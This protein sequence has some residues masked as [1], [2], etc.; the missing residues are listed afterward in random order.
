MI[1]VDFETRST[2]NLPETGVW[3]YAAHPDTGIWCMAFAIG[4]EEPQVWHE[5]EPF[6]ERL[7]ERIAAGETLASW[8]AQFERVIWDRVA[9]PRYGFPPVKLD[10]WECIM[11]RAAR[12]GFPLHLADAAKF[13]G[14]PEQKDLHGAA[15]MRKMCRPRVVVDGR[16]VWW[17]HEEYR[18]ALAAYCAQDV[19][20]E[21]ELAHRLPAL[22][23]EERRIFLLDARIND[24]GVGVDWELVDALLVIADLA[25]ADANDKL[26]QITEGQVTSIHQVA[27]LTNW[28]RERGVPIDSLAAQNLDTALRLD[29]PDDVY[30]V[31]KLRREAARTSTAKLEAMKSYRDPVDDRMHGLLQY[32]GAATGRWS[33]RGPQPQNFPR[34]LSDYPYVMAWRMLDVTLKHESIVDAYRRINTFVPPLKFVAHTLRK[35][36]I[37]HRDKRLYIGDYSAI[38]ARVLAWIAGHH[39]LVQ[40]FARGEDIYVDMASRIY[41]VPKDAVTKGMRQIGKI[42]ILGLGYGMG[43]K[44]FAET[45]AKAG[46]DMPVDEAARVVDVYRNTHAPIPHLWWELER[47]AVEAVRKPGQ[48]VEV[49]ADGGPR[50]AFLYD[51]TWLL[52]ELPSGRCLHY[53]LPSIEQVNGRPQLSYLAW[54]N[55]LRGPEQVRLYGGLL[56]ENLVQATARDLL[57]HSMFTLEREGFEIVLTV[58]DEIVAENCPGQLEAFRSGFAS[59]PYWA[60]GLPIAVEV[61]EA[62]RYEK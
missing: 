17:D 34:P 62:E 1:H 20:T 10:Q 49:R 29:W 16:P 47:A 61:M 54:S 60:H 8:N 59:L 31:M 53:Y 27:A 46:V 40:A 44:K 42:A 18:K 51:Q 45:A 9:V 36:L 6:P 33:G 30:E 52:M 56:A 15:L 4:D 11:A 38:E 50:V 22:P 24:R 43:A 26:V 35:C 37:P 58:H 57:V 14:L 32:H 7:R 2:V 28:L 55:I 23:E 3:P 25:A 48:W 21:R 12:L 41:G 5:G 39:E 13:L 19:R